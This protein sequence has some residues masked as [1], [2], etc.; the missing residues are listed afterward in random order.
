MKYLLLLLAFSLNITLSVIA[1]VKGCPDPAAN[2]YNSTA[3]ENDGS[4]TY[5]NITLTPTLKFNLNTALS[6]SSGLL[7]WKNLVWTHNDSGNGPL[8]YGMNATSGANQ[9]T[10]TLSNATNIDWE[11]IA[12]DNSFIYIGDFGNNANGNRTDLKIYRAAKSAI[13]AGDTV[14]AS[15]INFSYNDQTDFSA[16]GANNTNFD[17]E[18]LIAYGDS[19]FLFIKDWVDNKTRLYKLPK[20]PGTYSATKIGELNVTG[21]ITGAEVLL[22]EKVIVLSGYNTLLSPFIYLLYDFTG[23]NFFDANKRKVALNAT[24]TQMEGICSK[25]STNFLVSNESYIKFP[26]N[27]PAKLSQLNLASLLNP[28]YNS[29]AF[30]MKNMMVKNNITASIN[31]FVTV[32]S[33]GNHLYVKKSK[34]AVKAASINIYDING[35]LKLQQYFTNGET[36]INI[37]QLT[38]GFY[39]AK[40]SNEDQQTSIKFFKE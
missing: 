12:Q 35:I 21:L 36:A 18:A 14:T 25:S 32:Q 6:E 11:D 3:T 29:G 40:V 13:T 16:K 4:C 9:R 8:I 5:N 20:K 28:Y 24:F 26:I 34:P 17:C 37:H 39:I 30:S 15:V 19:L 22:T 38:Q 33:L 27:T 7:N 23:N 31:A 2:N 10:V 1:Q